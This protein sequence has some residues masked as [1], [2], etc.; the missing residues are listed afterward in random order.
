MKRD[1]AQLKTSFKGRVIVPED[2]EY[3]KFRQLFYGGID[4]KPA[5]IIRVADANDIGKAIELAKNEGLE[6]AIKSGGH[7]F[8]G[9]SM[10]DGGIVV[11]L[12]EMKK[13]EIDE[14]GKTVWA[15]T[16]LTAKELTDAVDKYNLVI[17]FGDTGSVGIGG[18]TLGGGV[19][20]LA[21]KFGLAIDNLLA[22]EIVTA[23]GKLLT[24]DEEN[25][26]DLFWA[27]RGGGGNFGVVT[28]FKYQLH[29]LGDAY[30]GIL[31]LPATSAV[32]AGFVELSFKAPEELSTIINI[33][34][35]P[36]M[37]M[38][39]AEVQGKLAIMAI[40]MYAGDPTMGE[41]VIAPMRALAKPYAD[42]I[43]PMRYKEIFFPEDE[44][45]H[46]TAVSKTMFMKSVDQGVAEIIMKGL[47]ESDASMRAVQLR[48]LGGAVSRVD[49]SATAY[50]HRQSQIMVNIAAFY[51]GEEEKKKRQ[52]WV[53]ELAMKLDQ[54]DDAA[55]VGFLG[56]GEESRARNAYPE[57]VWQRLVDIKRR[58]DPGN[59]FRL[60][61]N[62]NP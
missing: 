37:P 10:S 55:Y 31:M 17:G 52:D 27:I 62:I 53:D 42:M 20:Y 16:G 3:D 25:H 57:T 34:P 2:A 9:Y 54:G 15:E 56:P 49:P 29:T 51:A 22:A 35:A 26:P 46:P 33:M 6:L 32:I 24:V 23:D 18:I 45:Y 40:M 50:A 39:P 59:F 21:R 13:I 8:A 1:I 44:S 30:G 43:K 19:G 5:L 58:Y 48:V 11:D 4:K 7:S 41:K 61:F 47:N 14:F 28:R 12:G 38:I 36:P 60:N